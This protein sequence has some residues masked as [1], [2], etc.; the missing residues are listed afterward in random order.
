VIQ[1]SVFLAGDVSAILACHQTS[2]T[3]DLVVIAMQPCRLGMGH[4][5]FTDFLMD[6]SVLIVKR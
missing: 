4:F 1:R 6:S 3:A 2:F 5:D